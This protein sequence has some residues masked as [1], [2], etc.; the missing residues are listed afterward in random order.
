MPATEAPAS[1]SLLQQAA[2]L[3]DF[4]VGEEDAAAEQVRV[5]A[6][7]HLSFEHDA[8]D[9]AFDGAGVPAHA[10]AVGGGVPA[11]AQPGDERLQ[12]RLAGGE[13]GVHPGCG[14]AGAGDRAGT[15]A[16]GRNGTGL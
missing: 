4:Q 5:G 13:G 8:V 10:Q 14:A 15:G 9:V 11:G 3:I 2:R 1:I 7:V 6:S 16:G 12:G